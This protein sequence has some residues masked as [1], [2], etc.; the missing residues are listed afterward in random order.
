MTHRRLPFRLLAAG[1]AVCRLGL[2]IAGA[3]GAPASPGPSGSRDTLPL[4]SPP[5]QG[6]IGLTSESSRPAWPQQPAAPAGAPN[7][8][9]V[10]TD[11]I[12]F[13]AASAF[14][15]PIPT[16]ALERLA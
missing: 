13:G 11:D 15:G 1:L 9:V 2:A 12:G 10:L 7:V 5:F 4:P 8:L 6:R 3:P 16:P 14:G